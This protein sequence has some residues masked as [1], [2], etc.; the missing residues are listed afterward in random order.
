[1]CHFEITFYC[2]VVLMVLVAAE[3]CC[4]ELR[5]QFCVSQLTDY[6]SSIISASVMS[7]LIVGSTL[8]SPM[9]SHQ[10]MFASVFIKRQV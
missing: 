4:T 6:T 5:Q 1:M 2:H 3:L 8:M 9:T 7:C 10:G